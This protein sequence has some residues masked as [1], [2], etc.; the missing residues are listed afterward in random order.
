MGAPAVLI[1]GPCVGGGLP[2][3]ARC[4]PRICGR[5][6][7]FGAP[8][9]RLGMTLAYSGLSALI[10]ARILSGEPIGDADR[11]EHFDCF[12]TADYRA[13]YEAFLAKRKPVSEGR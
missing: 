7:R 9:S 10:G 1:E 4:D 8:I 2:L 5:G 12:D 3:A 6:S 11:A 13:G